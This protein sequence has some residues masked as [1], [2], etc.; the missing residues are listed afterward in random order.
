MNKITEQI[1]SQVSLIED[2]I[3]TRAGM[4]GAG[5]RKHPS[6]MDWRKEA[7]KHG[8]LERRKSVSFLP[9]VSIV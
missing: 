2:E 1:Y 4:M 6:A 7:D 8:D 9:N 3:G 5:S